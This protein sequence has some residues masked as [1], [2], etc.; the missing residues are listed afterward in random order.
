M[1]KGTPMRLPA[2]FS[3]ETLQDKREWHNISKVSKEKKKKPATKN[4]VHGEA[5]LLNWKSDKQ[6]FRQAKA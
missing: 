6:F 1:Y 3:A 2:D 4:T 5:V